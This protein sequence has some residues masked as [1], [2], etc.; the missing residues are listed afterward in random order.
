MTELPDSVAA[1]NNSHQ[2][3][4]Y[5][6]IGYNPDEKFTQ[7]KPL[8]ADNPVVAATLLNHALKV[9]PVGYKVK[10]KIPSENPDAMSLMAKIGFSTESKVPDMI[11]FNKCKFQVNINKVYS[12]LNGWNQFA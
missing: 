9:V 2:I 12:V 11:M 3:V 6:G 4:G 1:V 7:I 10:A 8:L 5:V